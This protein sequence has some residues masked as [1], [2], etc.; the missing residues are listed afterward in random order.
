M[1]SCVSPRGVGGR[2]RALGLQ[3]NSQNGQT[4]YEY[5]AEHRSGVRADRRPPAGPEGR[6]EQLRDELAEPGLPGPRRAAAQAAT[7]P[8]PAAS[9]SPS[10]SPSAQLRRTR[11]RRE[12]SAPYVT[13]LSN[14]PAWPIA[15]ATIADWTMEF[16]S[17]GRLDLTGFPPEDLIDNRTTAYANLIHPADRAGRLG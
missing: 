4:L 16:V 2:L 5:R 15:A 14:L 3:P 8:S 6:V 11:P 12:A 1:R 17:E 13:L 9:A 10:T 7:A